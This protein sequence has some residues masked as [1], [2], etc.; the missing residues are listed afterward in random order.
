MANCF[1]PSTATIDSSCVRP[2]DSLQ[3]C[4]LLQCISGI[5]CG[6]V[7]VPADSEKQQS[8]TAATATAPQPAASLAAALNDADLDVRTAVSYTLQQL[9]QRNSRPGQPEAGWIAQ[10]Q[11]QVL[12]AAA[13][14]QA[15]EQQHLYTVSQSIMLRGAVTMR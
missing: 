5:L 13:N 6:E 2:G 3:A 12:K 1:G 10:V 11:Q 14:E 7:L 4:Y 9:L 8:G 15:T